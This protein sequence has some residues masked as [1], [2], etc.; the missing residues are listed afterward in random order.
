[1]ALPGTSPDLQ[2]GTNAR[3]LD[4][5]PNPTACPDRLTVWIWYVAGCALPIAL[6][7]EVGPVDTSGECVFAGEYGNQPVYYSATC[8]EDGDVA[9]VCL[10]IGTQEA[11]SHT[12]GTACEYCI[13]SSQQEWGNN[14]CADTIFDLS[15]MWTGQCG[16]PTMEPTALP[17]DTPGAGGDGGPSELGQ[18]TFTAVVVLI[19]VVVLAAVSV[20]LAMQRR[21]RL[22][23]VGGVPFV[24]SVRAVVGANGSIT[25]GPPPSPSEMPGP[26]Q[27]ME[28]V[29]TGQVLAPQPHQ[30]GKAVN[31]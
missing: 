6:A 31:F 2:A 9:N 15:L 8:G 10:G 22:P 13:I 11:G 25:G 19:A 29:N 16:S 1:V 21:A 3:L 20:T 18:A 12:A 26:E 17:T 23:V 28:M 5:V 4:L 30:Q 24:G 14:Q 27:L 7:G